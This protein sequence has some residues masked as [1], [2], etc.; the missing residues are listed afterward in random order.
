[1]LHRGQRYFRHCGTQQLIA[2][3]RVCQ[4]DGFRKRVQQA[5]I[6]HDAGD[7]ADAHYSDNCEQ[8]KPPPVPDQPA[9]EL[10][11]PTVP[12]CIA[13]LLKLT[14]KPESVSLSAVL[15]NKGGERK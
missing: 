6:A 5:D 15:Q 3:Q 8:Y 4:Y 7:K 10:P 12:Q 2:A 11:Q 13:D 9:A 14:Q 1:M